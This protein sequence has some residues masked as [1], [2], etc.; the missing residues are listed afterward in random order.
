[1]QQV[2]VQKDNR[3]KWVRLSE[4]PIE[5]EAVHAWFYYRNVVENQFILCASYILEHYTKSNLTFK[6]MLQAQK[7]NDDTRASDSQ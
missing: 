1:M 5:G 3:A 6:Q 7:R 4:T 2:W